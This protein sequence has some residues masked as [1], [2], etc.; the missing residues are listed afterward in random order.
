M[1]VPIE[2]AIHYWG[3]PVLLVSTLNPDGTCNL[4]PMSSAWWL[5]W[6]CML[7]F[8]ASSQTVRNLSR[9]RE[10]VLNLC[11]AETAE[12]VNRLARTTGA[13]SV[14]LHK[15][16]L[17]YRHVA[18]KA[19]HAG[20]TLSPS[21]LVKAPRV[22]ECLVQLE[23]EVVAIRPFG[24]RDP[25]LAIPA[26]AVELRIVR[27]HADEGLLAAP[28]RV[29]PARWAPLLMSFRALF[30]RGPAALDT[31]ELARG[32]ESLYAPWK[33]G[34]LARLAA[35]GLGAL[36]ELRHGREDEPEE[37]GDELGTAPR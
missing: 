25:R 35:K 10:C 20:L 4:A 34:G 30:V 26:C 28:D 6:S 5:G 37:E 33:R 29:D 3:T 32:D 18:R 13:A 17:G 31:S 1:H 22:R 14:P 19:E 8:D 16:L 12:A 27:A 15:Q 36:L 11:S 23:A 2:P 24:R 21:E 7:G 9:A